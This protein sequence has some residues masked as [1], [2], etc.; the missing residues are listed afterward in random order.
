MC[1]FAPYIQWELK[2]FNRNITDY[3]GWV[4]VFTTDDRFR[5]SES[6]GINEIWKEFSLETANRYKEQFQVKNYL[7]D[8][9]W[10]M[11][12]HDVYQD[13]WKEKIYAQTKG[14]SLDTL[15]EKDV[16]NP[17]LLQPKEL[18]EKWRVWMEHTVPSDLFGRFLYSG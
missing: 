4:Y 11:N 1:G 13:C 12:L 2:D 15:I 10:H 5:V 7:L 6:S 14:E 16:Y 9:P 17:Q 3:I 8:V 18:D